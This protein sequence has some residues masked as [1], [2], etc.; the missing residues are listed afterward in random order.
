MTW[1]WR[2]PGSI[3]VDFKGQLGHVPSIIK[4]RLWFYQL[5]PHYL[6]CPS[7]TSNIFDKSTPMAE[8]IDDIRFCNK[9]IRKELGRR[10]TSIIIKIRKR[11]HIGIWMKT[12]DKNLADR[13]MDMKTAFDTRSI[14]E[15]KNWSYRVYKPRLH[16]SKNRIYQ[17]R[18]IEESPNL[19]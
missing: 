6:G 9:I 18:P 14:N 2:I 16:P 11:G 12:S 13:D 17:T 19:Q 8:R 7:N 3:G 10:E 15:R 5:F 1:L 4:K